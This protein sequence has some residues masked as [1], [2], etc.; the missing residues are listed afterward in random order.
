MP[1][2]RDLQGIV[3]DAR[4]DRIYGLST[5]AA[6]HIFSGQL[7]R[8][9]ECRD[10]DG[11]QML[12][13]AHRCRSREGSD[14]LPALPRGDGRRGSGVL[15]SEAARYDSRGTRVAVAGVRRL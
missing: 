6:P 7:V 10:R 4:G 15:E 12:A 14:V 2:A 9:R 3:L 8:S 11:S 13:N 5:F 1:G